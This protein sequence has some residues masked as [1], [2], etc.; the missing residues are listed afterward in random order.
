MAAPENLMYRMSSTGIRKGDDVKKISEMSVENL[1][2]QIRSIGAWTTLVSF[3]LPIGE[4]KNI[5]SNTEFLQGCFANMTEEHIEALMP[6]YLDQIQSVLKKQLITP[7]FERLH[8][9]TPL[10]GLDLV[11]GVHNFLEFIGSKVS[12]MMSSLAQLNSLINLYGP[13]SYSQ[14][15]NINHQ[16]KEQLIQ[17]INT[18]FFSESFQEFNKIFYRY[19]DTTFGLVVTVHIDPEDD[20]Q[21]FEAALKQIRRKNGTLRDLGWLPILEQAFS[22][23]AFTRIESELSKNYEAKVK[24]LMGRLTTRKL[25]QFR[26][27]VNQAVKHWFEVILPKSHRLLSAWKQRI[28]FFVYERFGK[29]RVG[30]IFDIIIAYP[31]SEPA[32]KDLK[33]CVDKSDLNFH[34]DM[35]NCFTKRLLHPGARTADII[36][37]YIN[38]I[39]ALR[40]LEPSGVALQRVGEPIREYLQHRDDTVRSVVTH[41]LDDNIMQAEMGENVRENSADDNADSLNW[42]PDPIDSDPNKLGLLKKTND[43]ISYLVRVFG[44]QDTFVNE[45]RSLLADRLLIRSEQFF[46]V[47]VE[48]KN[49]EL[50]KLRFGEY[51]LHLCDVMVRDLSISKRFNQTVS[52]DCRA[53]KNISATI[54]SKE[55]WP[56]VNVDELNL[57]KRM[58]KL[59]DQFSQEYASRR[60]PRNLRWYPCLGSVELDLELAGKHISVTC[61]TVCASALMHLSDLQK[62]H[63]YP[64]SFKKLE[65]AV[66]NK[67]LAKSMGF[68]IKRGIVEETHNKNQIMFQLPPNQD[69]ELKAYHRFCCSCMDDDEENTQAFETEL[70]QERDDEKVSDI[71]LGL[72]SNKSADFMKLFNMFKMYQLNVQ[73]NE[74]ILQRTL[75]KLLTNNKIEYAEGL[76][77]RVGATTRVSKQTKI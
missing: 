8:S 45:Y 46:N 73:I 41:M 5:L 70:Q 71:V 24:T 26:D 36:L 49:L 4:T 66:G 18:L 77:K 33:I 1:Q 7:G 74:T 65:K 16:L 14:N 56:Q 67:D 62:N 61:S 27:W 17:M 42:N 57:P 75:E 28:D 20:V 15:V 2:A 53:L 40:I 34:D 50:L 38:T 22:E 68:W 13:S 12:I 35:V 11:K 51:Q 60:K 6:W 29:M 55:Y 63:G 54:I 21:E 72:L 47:D 9:L 23:V 43:I 10:C 37:T 39:K 64:V 58:K 30:E 44:N 32:L 48:T 31:S 3:L 19:Y 52:E 69:E 25:H 76:Y 59:F